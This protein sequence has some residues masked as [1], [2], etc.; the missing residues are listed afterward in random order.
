MKTQTDNVTKLQLV[1]ELNV[2]HLYLPKHFVNCSHC[3]KE[4]KGI[5]DIT[6]P[7]PEKF[8]LHELECE[9]CNK[10]VLVKYHLEPV[11]FSISILS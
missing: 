9:H 10:I 5:R 4:I 8:E 6:Y 3:G 1:D 2:K 11:V 7:I